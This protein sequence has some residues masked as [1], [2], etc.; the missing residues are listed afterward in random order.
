M[1]TPTD[2]LKNEAR[3]AGGEITG[4]QWL[5]Y[6]ER[7]LKATA[8]EREK[9]TDAFL[10]GLDQLGARFET[11][12]ESLNK[13]LLRLGIAGLLAAVVVI[14]ILMRANFNFDGSSKGVSIS[15]SAEAKTPAAVSGNDTDE[16]EPAWLG[17]PPL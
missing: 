17:T 5:E 1:P 2:D 16:S 9:Q 11:R 14:A 3:A 10:G 7:Q 13:T 4:I 6:N 8:K 12:M 15:T